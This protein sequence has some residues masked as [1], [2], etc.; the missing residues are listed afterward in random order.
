MKEWWPPD[1]Q[2][3][4]LPRSYSLAILL[5]L[6]GRYTLFIYLFGT[7]VNKIYCQ[8]FK[9]RRYLSQTK[10]DAH[11][12]FLS[13]GT[14][15]PSSQLVLLHRAGGSCFL[16]EQWWFGLTQT[17]LLTVAWPI[18]RLQ[19]LVVTVPVSEDVSSKNPLTPMLCKGRSVTKTV[20]SALFSQFS[21]GRLLYDLKPQPPGGLAMDSEDGS[22]RKLV[23][24]QAGSWFL[25]PLYLKASY[26]GSGQL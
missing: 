17:P 10:R 11:F 12:W 14:K 8:L 26:G 18:K 19:H 21:A 16:Y 23:A 13:E 1:T 22:G 9:T 24:V 25:S 6:L 3:R 20:P 4:R 5:C 2:R 7:C 15:R